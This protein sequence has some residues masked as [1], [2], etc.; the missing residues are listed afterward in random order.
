MQKVKCHICDKCKDKKNC[1]VYNMKNG[2]S[3]C[4]K[5]TIGNTK[6]KGGINNGNR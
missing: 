2:Y 3:A 5:D 6:V 1:K 4:A